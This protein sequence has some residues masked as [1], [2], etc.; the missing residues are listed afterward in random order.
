[1]NKL[2]PMEEYLF[3]L[4]KEREP[5]HA[6][7]LK[8]ITRN[9]SQNIRK[10]LNDISKKGLIYKLDKPNCNAPAVWCVK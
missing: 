3:N 1:M 6:N 4:V 8:D 10:Y 2:T 7:T 9:S 5:V